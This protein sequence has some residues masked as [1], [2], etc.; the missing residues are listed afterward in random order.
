MN[1]KNMAITACWILFLLGKTSL[2]AAAAAATTKIEIPNTSVI[3]PN[4][5]G[6]V[7]LSV[8]DKDFSSSVRISK[9]DDKFL[10]TGINKATHPPTQVAILT[11]TSSEG[12]NVFGIEKMH[13]SP[14]SKYLQIKFQNTPGFT[15]YQINPPAKGTNAPSTITKVHEHKPNTKRWES[16]GYKIKSE[17]KTGSTAKL[18][19]T[20]GPFQMKPFSIITGMAKVCS[21]AITEKNLL[22]IA[23]R[24]KKDDRNS[25][26]EIWSALF[27]GAQTK[28]C[29]FEVPG[30]VRYMRLGEMDYRGLITEI[31]LFYK[32]GEVMLLTDCLA[33]NLDFVFPWSMVFWNPK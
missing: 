25:C 19:V 18:N 29:F 23:G 15:I 9:Q 16:R 30:R 27:N 33:Q 7:T 24:Q 20:T 21:I 10:I 13:I 1:I 17:G 12:I 2:A 28:L 14:D 4:Q 8:G 32:K 11:D 3:Y 5:Q 26:I 22:I 6:D 31:Y